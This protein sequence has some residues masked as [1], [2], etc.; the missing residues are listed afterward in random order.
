MFCDL[1]PSF[2]LVAAHVCWLSKL[3]GFYQQTSN[4][5][6]WGGTMLYL[7]HHGPFLEIHLL[8]WQPAFLWF[9]SPRCT[10]SKTATP[11]KNWHNTA[12]IQTARIVGRKSPIL[13]LSYSIGIQWHSQQTII[14]I[15]SMW[16]SGSISM[17]VMYHFFWPYLGVYPVKF[18][19]KN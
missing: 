5:H 3:A 9:Y 8:D 14:I 1:D 11:F 18:S 10:P 16:I 19:P 15:P 12:N 4:K 7:Y 13:N 2:S 6:S 17:E